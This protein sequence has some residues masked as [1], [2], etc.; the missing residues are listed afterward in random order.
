MFNSTFEIAQRKLNS[1]SIRQFH[2]LILISTMLKNANS[3]RFMEGIVTS[4]VSVITAMQGYKPCIVAQNTLRL[5]STKQPLL[6]SLAPGQETE[7]QYL[8]LSSGSCQLES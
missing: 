5:F 3:H 1:R 7:L 6:R 8:L 4:S 2:D